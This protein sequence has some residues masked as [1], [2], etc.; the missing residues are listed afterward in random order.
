MLE[1]DSLEP[2]DAA[3]D[4]AGAEAFRLGAHAAEQLL[5][6][7]ALGEAGVVVRDRDPGRSAGTRVEH[8]EVALEAREVDR[9]RQAG[10]PTADD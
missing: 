8:A 9:R 7:D 3:M 2:F 1:R 10:G 4:D 5:A 6:G